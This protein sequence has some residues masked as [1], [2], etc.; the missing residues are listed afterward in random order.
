MPSPRRKLSR[1]FRS[2]STEAETPAA[3]DAEGVA[4]VSPPDSGSSSASVPSPVDAAMPDAGAAAAPAVGPVPAPPPGPADGELL[5]AHEPILEPMTEYEL[6]PEALLEPDGGG[7]T[8]FAADL[9]RAVTDFGASRPPVRT[10]EWCNRELPDPMPPT[11]PN[12]G[13]PLAP[14]EPD[15]E[16]P[17]LTTMSMEALYA[18]QLAETKRQGA[19]A[20]TPPAAATPAAATDQPGTGEGPAGLMGVQLEGSAQQEA[21]RPPDDQV[22]R[23]MLQM[24]IEQVRGPLQGEDVAP[25]TAETPEAPAAPD[26]ADAA[27]DETG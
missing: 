19:A 4:P 23:M 20:A 25:E 1:P 9:D 13:A 24:E 2:P 16:I 7:D 27:G 5:D 8:A 26:A 10:C 18:R 3:A 14:A 11:C 6:A 17:G 21:V 22:R 15:L 12:C